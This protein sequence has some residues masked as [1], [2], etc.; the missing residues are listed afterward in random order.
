VPTTL[1]Q[2][3]PVPVD[4]DLDL[5]RRIHDDIWLRTRRSMADVAYRNAPAYTLEVKRQVEGPELV[6]VFSIV[7][8]RDLVVKMYNACMG[9][10]LGLSVYRMPP[11]PGTD[12]VFVLSMNSDHLVCPQD[13]RRFDHAWDLFSPVVLSLRNLRLHRF[14]FG[15]EP[16]MDKRTYDY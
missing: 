14:Q 3:Q 1:Q 9:F 8:Q 12:P 6:R 15:K 7:E 2:A 10:G 16:S 5:L 11:C 13:T 4:D